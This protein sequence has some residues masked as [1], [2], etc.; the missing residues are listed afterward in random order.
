MMAVLLPC[1]LVAISFFMKLFIDRS[2]SAPLWAAS[3]YELPVDVLFLSISF[4]VAGCITKKSID[5]GLI[6]I[7]TAIAVG[8]LSTFLWRRSMSLFD[9]N[10]VAWSIV[11]ST[12][13]AGISAFA[14]YESVLQLVG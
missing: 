11:L 1:G 5:P 9:R 12:V 14:L 8:F 6:Y 7:F 2:T 10:H 4:F 13:N 3:L